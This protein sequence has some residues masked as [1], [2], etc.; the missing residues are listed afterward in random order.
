MEPPGWSAYLQI[1]LESLAFVTLICSDP[2][3]PSRSPAALILWYRQRMRLFFHP[4]PLRRRH[5]R[6]ACSFHVRIVALIALA[7]A[8]AF[9]PLP[10]VAQ[11]VQEPPTEEIV[12][13]FAAGRVVIA[14]VKD[15]ILIGT[16]EN[17]IEPQTHPPIPMQMNRA[18]A[19]ILLGAVDW[20]S[21]SSQIQLARLDNELPHLH[22][23]FEVPS[24]HINQTPTTAEAS[25][26]EALGQNLYERINTV[27]GNLHG[28]VDWPPTAPVAELILAD[29]MQG[30]GPEVWQLT[31][32]LKQEMQREDYFDT[33][34]SH[35]VYLQSW[36]PE[37]GQPHTLV[38]FQY[39][40]DNA[41]PT[42]LDLL[43]QKDPRLE[44]ICASDAK[45]REVAD[46]FLDGQSGKVLAVDA[47]QFL[48]AVLA[49][50]APPN[51]RETMA[52]I[53]IDTGFDWILRPP[54]EPKRPTP[55]TGQ[56]RPAEAPSLLKGS[57]PE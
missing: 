45:M 33:H 29:Y 3:S 34:V 42:L 19:G 27:A 43:R 49:V 36:P 35:P 44:K 8:I 6:A 32:T 28:K 54:A 48:R 41:T 47:T 7:I 39:P 14:V 22:G 23:H 12:V 18:R 30:Y 2:E 38:E 10:S 17:K 26:L 46:R 16:I 9:L 21:P 1:L 51:A 5:H 11:Q 15:A 50:L 52:A 56:E 31:F 37:K 24:P 55:Q 13:N 57:T 20:F 53:N 4:R 40:P 25:D